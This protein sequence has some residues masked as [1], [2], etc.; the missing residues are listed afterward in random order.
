[1]SSPRQAIFGTGA[2]GLAS[3]YLGPRGGAQSMLGET[4]TVLGD[5]D[6]PH[7]Y[8]YIPDIGEGLAVLGEHPDAHGESGTSPTT[9]GPGPP[10]TG[11]SP[12]RHPGHLPHQTQL[13]SASSA[14]DRWSPSRSRASQG[15]WASPTTRS[16]GSP[17]YGR[18]P[19]AALWSD[20]SRSIKSGTQRFHALS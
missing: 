16:P 19:T 18:P 17:T 13:G 8:T 10:A 7:T 2:I 12:R 9:P 20:S 5:P 6:Q 15:S 1:M 11:P 14:L 3:D 4:A